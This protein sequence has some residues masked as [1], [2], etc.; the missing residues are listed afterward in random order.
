[1]DCEKQDILRAKSEIIAPTLQTRE[2]AF[3]DLKSSAFDPDALWNRVDGDGD[4]LRDLVA[5][6]AIEAPAM[7]SRIGKA[8]EAGDATDLEKGGHKI[9]GSLL[10]LAAPAAA[11]TAGRLE[12]LASSGTLAGTETLRNTLRQEVDFLMTKLDAMVRRIG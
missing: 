8:I 4:L 5:V 2:P 3:D 6:F 7:L 9:K 12:A 1:M 11:A 10:Q